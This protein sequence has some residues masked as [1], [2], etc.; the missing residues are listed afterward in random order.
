[1]AAVGVDADAGRVQTF[2]LCLSSGWASIPAAAAVP[3][4]MG[5]EEVPAL[6]RWGHDPQQSRTLASGHQEAGHMRNGG[7]WTLGETRRTASHA[8]PGG[9][10]RE[11][12]APAHPDLTA[13]AAPGLNRVARRWPPVA[14]AGALP[15]VVDDF[16]DLVHPESIVRRRLHTPCAARPGRG[17]LAGD[18]S[19]RPPW[20]WG[21]TASA[22]RLGVCLPPIH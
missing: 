2:P 5:F 7:S 17:V 16:Y 4:F 6:V 13:S 20:L 1:M 21:S 8:T 18:Q 9:S 3:A 19:A 14:G 15:Q 12:R 10:P 22:Q 11:R